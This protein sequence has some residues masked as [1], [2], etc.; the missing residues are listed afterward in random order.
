[1]LFI[2]VFTIKCCDLFT[3][4]KSYDIENID[5]ETSPLDASEDCCK[6]NAKNLF[7]FF[8]NDTSFTTVAWANPLSIYWYV[9]SFMIFK[10]PLRDV[11]TPP[12]NPIS[13]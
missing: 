2:T 12:P 9:Y 6:K 1:M 7:P 11:L 10:E 5:E 3:V 4:F 8:E 13:A